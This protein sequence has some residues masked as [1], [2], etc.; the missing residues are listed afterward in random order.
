MSVHYTK[1]SLNERIQI[2][3]LYDTCIKVR[4]IARVLSRH[5]STTGF[6]LPTV[7]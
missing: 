6:Q 5:P 1:L 3:T 2:Q 4:A 7:G